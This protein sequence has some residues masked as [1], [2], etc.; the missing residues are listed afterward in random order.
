MDACIQTAIFPLM[1]KKVC[2]NAFPPKIY[3]IGQYRNQLVISETLF[4]IDFFFY[5][6]GHLIICSSFIGMFLLPD[7]AEMDICIRHKK[8]QEMT[9]FFTILV[10]YKNVWQKCIRSRPL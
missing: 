9:S 3:N 1:L 5:S 8:S 6:L 4:Y 2:L 7:K 10:D